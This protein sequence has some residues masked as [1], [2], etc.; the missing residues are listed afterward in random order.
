MIHAQKMLL[1]VSIVIIGGHLQAADPLGPETVLTTQEN[2][3]AYKPTAAFLGGSYLVI[4]KS[5]ILAPG[6]MREGFKYQSDI[7][8]CKVGKDGQVV[9]KTPWVISKAK[10]LQDAPQITA[11]KEMALVVW[12]DLR[13]GQDWDTYGAR[14]DAGGKVLDPGGFLIAGGANNQAKPRVAWDGKT[15]VVVWMDMRNGKNY[16]IYATRVRADGPSAGSAQAKVVDPDGIQVTTKGDYD[17]AICSSGD[18]RSF[19][20]SCNGR[21]RYDRSDSSQ[22][23]GFLEGGKYTAVHP[24]TDPCDFRGN[25]PYFAAAGKDCYLYAWRNEHWNGRAQG[26]PDYTATLCGKDGLKKKSFQLEGAPHLI[27]SADIVWDGSAFVAAYAEYR[28]KG[29]YEY[30]YAQ[31]VAKE[32]VLASRI[33]PEGALLGPAMVVSDVEKEPSTNPTVASDGAGQTLIAYEKQPKTGDVAIQIAFRM[34]SVAP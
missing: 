22:S 24:F 16:N 30:K 3:D 6:D 13:N 29:K 10:G 1:A 15:F 11:N 33:S 34:L 17:P 7:V 9:D 31:G 23:A 32:G 14:I 26:V 4:W 8:A 28:W 12:Q 2:K 5:G 27:F 25:T 19:I 20:L 18:G 21:W